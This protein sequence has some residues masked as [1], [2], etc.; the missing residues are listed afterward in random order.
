MEKKMKEI[1]KAIF[2]K[3]EKKISFHIYIYIYIYIYINPLHFFN[4]F[5]RK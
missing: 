3:L 4:I 2:F 5:V 1:K